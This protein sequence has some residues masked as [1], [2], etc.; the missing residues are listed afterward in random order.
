VALYRVNAGSVPADSWL[1]DEEGGGRIIGEVCHFVDTLQFLIGADPVSVSAVHA[2]DHR[3]ALSIQLMFS[4]GSIG[5]IIYSSLGDPSFP[6]EY[7]EL[8]G[9]GRV[10]VIDDFRDARLVTDGQHKRRRLWRQDKGTTGE[11][12]AFFRSLRTGGPMPLPLA[13]LVLTTL[14]TFAIEAS[15]RTAAPVKVA[16]V[17]ACPEGMHLQ[18]LSPNEAG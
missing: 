3:D 8:F 2:A 4:D 17:T 9:A 5:T 13:S 1:V 16:E 10:V 18:Q 12:E 11:L 15:L 7:I 6:K 14:T